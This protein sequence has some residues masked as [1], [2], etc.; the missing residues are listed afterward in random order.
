MTLAPLSEPWSVLSQPIYSL[1]PANVVM[2][3]SEDWSLRA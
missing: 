1:R 3:S 2:Q